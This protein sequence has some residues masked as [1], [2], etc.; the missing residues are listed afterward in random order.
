MADSEKILSEV[1][2]LAYQYEQV[3]GGCA[4]CVIAS[5]KSV[6][7]G[8]SEDVFKAAT[9][10]AGGM[11]LTGNNCGAFTGGVLV[12]STFKGRTLD[13]FADPEKVGRETYRMVRKLIDRFNKE[14]GSINCRNIQERIMGR[15]Y[16]LC[17]KNDFKEFLAAGGH[18]D[19][20][21]SVC[22]NSA[23]WAVEILMEE[24]LV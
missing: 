3:Y 1:G 16:N 19:K 18:D 7:G 4:Q 20:C 2:D 22:R 14:Y 11:G 10:L 21:P 13:N 6:L 5:V 9:G 17:D 8:I 12:L 15:S 23:V 24:G